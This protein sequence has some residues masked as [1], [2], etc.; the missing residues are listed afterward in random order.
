MIAA[1]LDG[2]FL[3]IALGMLVM[4]AALWVWAPWLVATMA[5]LSCGPP[6]VF[7]L[8]QCRPELRWR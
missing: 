6:A 5:S 7:M 4:I 3:A 2:F 1:G 8:W